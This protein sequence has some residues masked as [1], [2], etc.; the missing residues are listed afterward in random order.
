MGEMLKEQVCSGGSAERMAMDGLREVGANIP[1]V[2]AK[3]ARPELLTFS[4]PLEIEILGYDIE[5]LKELGEQIAAAL[6]RSDRFADV[7]SS[8][9]QGHP[10]IQIH[11]DQERVGN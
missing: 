5:R 9:E 6:S 4:T 10:E 11:F 8:L 1:G 7:K 2:Q 3:F